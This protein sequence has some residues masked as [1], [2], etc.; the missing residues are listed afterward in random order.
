[1]RLIS[2]C[3]MAL[4]FLT[5][6]PVVA[7]DLDA[8]AEE[9]VKLVLALGQHDSGYVDAYYGPPEWATGAEEEA[10]PLDAIRKQAKALRE[11][12]GPAPEDG[13]DLMKRLRHHY[14]YTQLGAVIAY[15]DKISGE[16]KQTFDQQAKALFDTEPPHIEFTIFDAA[17]AELEELLPGDAPLSDRAAA[18]RARFEI[19]ADRLGAVMDAAIAAC[20]ERTREYVELL[21]GENFT[22]EYVT[23]KPWSG[24]NWYKGSGYSLIQINTDL[25]I[26]IS[27]AVGLGCHE[28]YPGHHT[29]NAL[30]EQ[31]LTI[32]RRWVEYSVYPLFSPQSMIAEGS[33]NYGIDMAFPK[34]ERVRFETEVLF[35]LAGFDPALAGKLAAF[36]RLTTKLTFAGNEIARLYIDGKI[37]AEKATDLYRKY[38]ATTE[39]RARQRQR[40][41]EAYGVYVINYNWGKELVRRYIEKGD[42][43]SPAARWNRF[44]RLLSSPRLPSSL[45][46]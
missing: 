22:L 33:A 31:R 13:E 40:F 9:Y 42:D 25:P 29:Y 1:M 23:D 27:R 46:W 34:E 35:P 30:L 11:S 4:V 20:R 7:G 36:R 41:L 15:A 3:L 26:E 14:L 18:F 45:D 28:G 8:A 37:D 39:E 43:Q 6:A 12:V 5:P 2:F 24:Y 32:E 17:L 44:G 16:N 21:P 38:G 19:P 10:L